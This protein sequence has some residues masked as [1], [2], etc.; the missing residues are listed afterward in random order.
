M[1]QEIAVRKAQGDRAKR[2]YQLIQALTGDDHIEHMIQA[3]EREAA[4]I[5]NERNDRRISFNMQAP[6]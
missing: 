6:R 3:L 4:R 2:A 5:F 1:P